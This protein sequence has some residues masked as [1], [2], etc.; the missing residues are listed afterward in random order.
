MDTIFGFWGVENF[1][2]IHTCI[3]SLSANFCALIN[4]FRMVRKLLNFLLIN[5]L[6]FK[7]KLHAI[8]IYYA[9]ERMV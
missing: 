1:K 8:W 5:E 2:K 4:F 9:T 7:I 3:A 6:T